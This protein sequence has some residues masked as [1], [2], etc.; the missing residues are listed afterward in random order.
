MINY[1]L[2]NVEEVPIVIKETKINIA[3]INRYKIKILINLMM[4]NLWIIFLEKENDY[5]KLSINDQLYYIS[6]VKNSFA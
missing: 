3:K 6:L 5:Y 1:F 2:H 4:L